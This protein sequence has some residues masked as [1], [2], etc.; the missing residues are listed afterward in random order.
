IFRVF[1]MYRQF[2]LPLLLLLLLL[3]LRQAGPAAARYEPNWQSL[4]S[5]PLPGWYDQA[6]IGV[7]IHWGV[8]S[9]PGFGNEWFWWRWRGVPPFVRPEQPF[10]DF[11][12]ANYPPGFTYAD[13]AREFKAELFNPEAWADTL[14]RSG[15]K[16]VVLTSKHH[17][18]YCLWNTS[19]SF[20]WNSAQVGSGRNLLAELAAAIRNRSDGPRFGV[21]HSLYE[22]Y[23][24]LYLTDAQNNFVTQDFVRYKTMA[25]L[26]ELVNQYRPE[27]IW[28]DGDA[29]I[30]EYWNST[31]FL[32]WLYND[33]PVRDSVVTNDRWGFGTAC[34]HGGYFTCQDGYNPGKLVSYKFEN[35]MSLIKGSWGYVRNLRLT[36]IYSLDEMLETVVSTV[37][38]GGNVLM[39]IGPTSYGVIPAL[40]E[41]R[42]LQLGDWLSIN[43]EAVYN[44]TPWHLVQRDV[45]ATQL[46][47]YTSRPDLGSVYAFLM[48]GPPAPGAGPVRLA[49]P[50]FAAPGANATLLGCPTAA[51]PVRLAYR[52]GVSGVNMTLPGQANC[53]DLLSGPGGPWVVKINGLL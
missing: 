37:S 1:D 47:Y 4:D 33:S 9:V 8:F 23:N 14:S 44:S 42:L 6:K 20:N 49:S 45:N 22:W 25:E 34:K 26:Y 40:L 53:P 16:Y 35:A 24:P 31:E 46:V 43:G 48:S 41:E 38:Y 10:V 36:D 28:S 32:A 7:F 19:H 2:C 3:L 50:K 21:Y 39:N 51:P 11:M 29:G 30:P 5:R 17:E 13:F 27:V 12:A 15:A 52:P 18:G